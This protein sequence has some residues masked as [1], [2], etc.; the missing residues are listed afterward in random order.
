MFADADAASLIVSVWRGAP[1]AHRIKSGSGG[2]SMSVSLDSQETA[3]PWKEN[4]E[5]HTINCNKQAKFYCLKK[6]QTSKLQAD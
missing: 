2:S 6:R 3:P 1:E 5:I 4:V